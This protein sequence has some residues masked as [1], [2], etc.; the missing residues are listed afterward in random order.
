MNIYNPKC[1][2]NFT[3]CQVYF[4][5]FLKFFPGLHQS[6]A[7]DIFITLLLIDSYVNYDM[8]LPQK[9]QNSSGKSAKAGII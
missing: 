3:Y 5:F 2:V 1:K 4:T 6:L 9:A 7:L 8:W